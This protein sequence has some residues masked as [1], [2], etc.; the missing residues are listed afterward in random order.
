MPFCVCHL[1]TPPSPSCLNLVTTEE[2]P[3]VAAFCPTS[4]PAAATLA[5]VSG[6]SPDPRSLASSPGVATRRLSRSLFLTRRFL[7]KASAW[8]WR[9]YTNRPKDTSVRKVF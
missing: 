6:A 7:S 5:S 9:R 3:E 1:R 8:P 4:S 2:A